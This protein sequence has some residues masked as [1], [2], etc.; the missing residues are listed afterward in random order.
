MRTTLP[1]SGIRRNENS[2][3]NLDNAEGP[4]TPG[5]V[6]EEGKSCFVFRQFWQSLTTEGISDNLENN[7]TQIEYNRTP[8]QR[9]N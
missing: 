2:I 4:G 3:I 8:R 1:I 9:Y 5:G 7:V 6:C